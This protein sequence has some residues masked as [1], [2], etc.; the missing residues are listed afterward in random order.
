MPTEGDR[1]ADIV[2]P[3]LQGPLVI[4]PTYR[5]AANIVRALQN[6]RSTVPTSTVLVVDDDGAD[7]T[8]DWPNGLAANL[9]VLKSSADLL[10]TVLPALTVAAS[11]GASNGG[12]RSSSGWTQT[13][14]M[15]LPPSRGC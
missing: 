1:P 12:T 2:A 6:V 11:T 7:G 13:S 3:R 14:L 9:V 4:M 10:S 15:T 8:A 5:E